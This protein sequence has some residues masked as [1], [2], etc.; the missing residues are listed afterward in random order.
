MRLSKEREQEIREKLS[1]LST[2]KDP[3]NDGLWFLAVNGVSELL[4]EID[5]LRNENQ[6]QSEAGEA[7]EH[8]KIERDQL[9]SENEKLK[10]FYDTHVSGLLDC[11]RPRLH[12]ENQKLRERI[13]RMKGSLKFIKQCGIEGHKVGTAD[14]HSFKL[15]EAAG[16]ASKALA[17]DDGYSA[18]TVTSP[19]ADEL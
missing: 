9:K 13:E 18:E 11:D 7:A 12:D 15:G 16:T 5:A 4:A 3:K 19:P 6:F 2:P 8:Y 1:N 14:M 10:E 17:D